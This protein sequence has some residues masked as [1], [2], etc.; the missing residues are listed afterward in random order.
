MTETR[1]QMT[2]NPTQLTDRKCEKQLQLRKEAEKR[3]NTKS[4]SKKT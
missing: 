3:K 2:E 1:G 4:S